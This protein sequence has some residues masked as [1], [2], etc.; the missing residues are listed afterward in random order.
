MLDWPE[1]RAVSV[2][3]LPA[4]MAF[5]VQSVAEV[6]HPVEEAQECKNVSEESSINGKASH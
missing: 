2:L 4:L 3:L 1:R 6:F 5:F